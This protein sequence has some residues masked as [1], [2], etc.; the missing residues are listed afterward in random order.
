MVLCSLCHNSMFVCVCVLYVGWFNVQEPSGL[1]P[2]PVS[3]SQGQLTP[4]VAIHS[5]VVFLL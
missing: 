3:A 4:S 5:G 1:Q 2:I